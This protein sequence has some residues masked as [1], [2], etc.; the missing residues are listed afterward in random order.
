MPLLPDLTSQIKV[1]IH[2][3]IADDDNF[4]GLIAGSIWIY[5]KFCKDFFMFWIY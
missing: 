1:F 5:L 2:R 4:F 3:A